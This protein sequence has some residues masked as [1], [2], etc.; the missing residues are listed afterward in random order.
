MTTE[1]QMVLEALDKTPVLEV[2][3]LATGL[4][5]EEVEDVIAR[6]RSDL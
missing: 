1:E 3:S 2:I 5:T 6:M 4:S